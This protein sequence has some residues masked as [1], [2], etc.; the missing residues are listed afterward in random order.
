[1]K[2]KTTII[3]T[4]VKT[5]RQ[6]VHEDT[7]LVT[8]ALDKF[9]NIHMAMNIAPNSNCLLPIA[10]QALGGLMLFDGDLIENADNIHFP[11][12]VHLVGY[13][14]QDTNTSDK[15]RGSY[16]ALE[17]G[18]TA[19]GFVSVW[20]FGT[21]Q[22]NGTI[23]SL[24]RTNR[25]SGQCPLYWYH[26]DTYGSTSNGA[27]TTDN[28]WYPIR[29]DGEYLYAL[30]GNSTT[31]IMRL[32]RIKIPMISFGAAD[33]SDVARTYEVI[34]SWNT[35]VTVYTYYD[36]QAKMNAGQDPHDQYVY[37]DSPEQYEDGHDGYIYCM[38]YGARRQYTSYNYDI[39]YFTIN[40]GNNSYER[41]STVYLRTGLS[42][43][44]DASASEMWYAGRF[45][46]HVHHGVLYRM[47]NDRKIMDIIPLT[48]LAGIHSV[49]VI[50]ADS[51]DYIEDLGRARPHNGGVWLEIYHY[52]ET[53]YNRLNGI[54]YPDATFILIEYSYQGTGN[55][56]GGNHQYNNGAWTVDDDLTVWGF[57]NSD[58]FTRTWVANYLGTINNLEAPIVK[59]SAQTMKI[60]YTLTDVT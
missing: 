10:T 31:H 25:W 43:W 32:A 26:G 49:R 7:N 14:A 13:A 45:R 34:A 54:L 8:H 20:D 12:D 3:L 30:K 2:G 6:E 35:L 53:G 38:F 40:Y 21:S 59:T 29:Y 44:T 33:Y 22:A 52:T 50:D 39:T 56:H 23:K 4:D 37:A 48:N 18:K 36:T 11:T 1:M 51:S 5:G 24:A 60:I 41:G 16:N 19:D 27:P 9:I 57:S 47:R 58:A 28:G 46:G 42:Y 17:S 15:Y 55:E